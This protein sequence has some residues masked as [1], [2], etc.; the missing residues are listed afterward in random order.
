MKYIKIGIWVILLFGIT[1]LFNI[2]FSMVFTPDGVKG[3][4][5]VSNIVASW[6][7]LIFWVALSVFAGSRKDKCIFVAGIIYS[8]LPFLGL[9][10]IPFLGT[11]L[12]FMV[13]ILFYWGVPVQGISSALVYLQLPIFLLGYISGIKMLEKAWWKSKREA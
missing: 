7:Y 11:R 3:A 13:L 4:V 12:A 9:I 1:V 6:A 5:T 8:S 10:G 2:S